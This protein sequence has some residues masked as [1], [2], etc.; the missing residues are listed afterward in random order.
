MAGGRIDASPSS[1]YAAAALRFARSAVTATRRCGGFVC[2]IFVERSRRA[3]PAHSTKIMQT[4]SQSR[5][6][7]SMFATP[8]LI[9]GRNPRSGRDIEAEH[10]S[11]RAVPGE[12]I[13]EV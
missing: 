8:D 13:L 12:S 6:Q 4:K 1:R 3:G 11:G 5:A 9:R 7:G 10:G 2:M